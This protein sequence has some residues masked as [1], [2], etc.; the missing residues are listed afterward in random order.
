MPTVLSFQRT[1]QTSHKF[2]R[3]V[4]RPENEQ[5]TLSILNP[6][7]GCKGAWYFCRGPLGTNGYSY[8]HPLSLRGLVGV[9]PQWHRAPLSFCFYSGSTL[10]SFLPLATTSN[11]VLGA[12][13]HLGRL[14]FGTHDLPAFR[15]RSPKGCCFAD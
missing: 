10:E 15:K 5:A 13:R 2:L 7:S 8:A 3:L 11:V 9:S 12:L 4:V 14:L 6:K 1:P